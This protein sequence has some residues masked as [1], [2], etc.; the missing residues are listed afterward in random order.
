MFYKL[1]ECQS[2]NGIDEYLDITGKLHYFL[3]SKSFGMKAS[4]RIESA[5]YCT[6]LAVYYKESLLPDFS[7]SINKGYLSITTK[8]KGR[9]LVLTDTVACNDGKVHELVLNGTDE[10]LTA[11]VDG[12]LAIEDAGIVPYCEF[13][14][15][16]FATI[17]RGTLQNQ[18]ASFF[19]G[20]ILG[21]E[22]SQQ[23]Y[24]VPKA[25]TKE[26]Q[27]K[28][29][30]LFGKGMSGAENY[31]IPAMITTKSGVVIATADARMDAPG[32]NPNHI[33]RGVRISRDSG[34]TWDE[35][36]LALDF[37]GTGR[38][39]GAAAIDGQLVQ[40]EATGTVF[41][42]YGHTGNGIGS[43][44]SQPGTGFDEEGRRILYGR[45][46]KTYVQ[47]EDGTV[48]DDSGETTPYRIDAYDILYKDGIE[49]GSVCHG[50]DRMFTIASTSFLQ[51]IES[52]DDGI[53]WSSPR[54]LNIL[55]KKPWMRFMG[56]GP[57]SGIC[58]KEGEYKGRL[59]CPVY[60]S[61][62]EGVYSSG[63]IYSDDHG[64]TWTCGLS[65]NDGRNLDETIL[66]A[67]KTNAQ[68]AFLGECQMAE[69]TGGQI[70]FFIR[71]PIYKRV[72]TAL[73]DDGGASWHS[74]LIEDAL[75]NPD[76]QCHIL[77]LEH[78][79]KVKY[80]YSG[81]DHQELRVRGSV[82]LSEDETQSWSKK[83]LL[84]SGEFA[85]SCMAVMPDGQIGILYEGLDIALYFT[86]FPMEWL[87]EV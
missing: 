69:L 31:R 5:G 16:G 38:E 62:P 45:D 66:C 8:S 4:Y 59:I 17:G 39:D 47:N 68:N 58:V 42:L 35:V 87:E 61:N 77:R 10:G 79:G 54:D 53:T 83:R 29:T 20:E 19:E 1:S 57:G 46:G 82:W 33:A 34:K 81:S 48:I 74:V 12:R 23:A 36:K 32:D 26:L 72:I 73:S 41:M 43:V 67:E 63:A 37:G 44:L 60:Y 27:L 2:F 65:V 64:K 22:L 15:V 11:W 7:V 24:P 56:P 78:K 50:E 52:H 13:G 14:Y 86:K 28:K 75:V 40:D 18:Y 84:E 85:Y 21:M 51:V 9:L 55:V 30:I 49:A 80:L 25:D 71:N 6:L 3:Q 70:K 76:C